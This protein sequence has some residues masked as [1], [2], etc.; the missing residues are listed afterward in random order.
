VTISNASPTSFN[1]TECPVASIIDGTHFTY[2]QMGDL[3]TGSTTSPAVMRAQSMI[4]LGTDTDVV[5]GS[6]IMG[7]HFEGN[8]QVDYAIEFHRASYPAVVYNDFRGLDLKDVLVTNTDSEGVYWGNQPGGAAGLPVSQTAGLTAVSPGG[9]TV[10]TGQPVFPL[11]INTPA[12]RTGTAASTDLAGTCTLGP[13]GC[14]FPFTGTYASPLI[15][16]ASDTNTASPSIVVP[17]A[18]TTA[19][20][21]TG[22]SGHVVN[23]IC[24][25][26]N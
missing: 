1:C 24:V 22:T 11:G 6:S 12:A 9:V 2:N 5:L 13:L 26:R 25:G 10:G 20:T 21:L 16:V 8:D 19:L 7:A 3:E 18:T 23:W 14:L 4:V 17:T 15:C